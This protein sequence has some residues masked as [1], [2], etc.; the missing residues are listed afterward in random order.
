MS[1]QEPKVP[2][3]SA[4]TLSKAWGALQKAEDEIIYARNEFNSAVLAAIRKQKL[5]PREWGVIEREDGWRF[6]QPSES[7]LPEG[8]AG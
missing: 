1:E 8:S 2:D 4:K 5:S 6:L 7:D 3:A